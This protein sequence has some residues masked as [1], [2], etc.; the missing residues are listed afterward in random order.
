MTSNDSDIRKFKDTKD[1]L[2]YLKEQCEEEDR[3]KEAQKRRPLRE[4]DQIFRNFTVIDGMS[5]L[6]SIVV[7]ADGSIEFWMK[8]FLVDED[9]CLQDTTH[10]TFTL[11]AHLR[12]KEL[13]DERG[14]S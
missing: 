1:L 10:E 13:T 2:V 6:Y 5:F 7:R 8:R 9:E 12:L 3:I 11:A 4:N 14:D